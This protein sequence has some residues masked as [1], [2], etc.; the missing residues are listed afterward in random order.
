MRLSLALLFIVLFMAGC[1]SVPPKNPDDPWKDYNRDMF[2]FNDSLD[3]GIVKPV[4]RAY[5]EYTPTPINNGISNFFSNLGDVWIGINNTLQGKIGNAFSD[6][7]RFTVNTT[8]G[9]FGLFDVASSI[10]LEKNNEDLGQTLAAW[11]WEDSRYFVVPFLGPSTV[12]DFG[13]SSIESNNAPLEYLTDLSDDEL[14]A[15]TVVDLIDFRAELLATEDALGDVQYGRY[16]LIRDAYME[17]RRFLIHDGKPPAKQEDD[18][19]NE[20]ELLD[21][22]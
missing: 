10:G 3:R 19:L 22:L 1:S 7:G 17:R 2:A 9:I 13:G 8:I 6:A 20:L 11:G 15:L 12:R 18:L 5:E 16:E 21:Q 14:L 4:A